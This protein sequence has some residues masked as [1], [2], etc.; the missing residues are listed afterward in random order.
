MHGRKAKCQMAE[1]PSA[2]RGCLLP[3]K[4]VKPGRTLPP[5]LTRERSL[6]P[7]QGTWGLL[8]AHIRCG[9]IDQPLIAPCSAEVLPLQSLSQ[10]LFSPAQD[11]AVAWE[12][13][14]L[15]GQKVLICCLHLQSMQL[16]LGVP[17][18]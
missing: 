13:P 3:G 11:S 15:G 17:V 2:A 9:T 10:E 18:L 5:R 4:R 6:P 1:R 7:S 8:P 12:A 16:L 14:D